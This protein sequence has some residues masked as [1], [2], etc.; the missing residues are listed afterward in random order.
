MQF[1]VHISGKETIMVRMEGKINETADLH[2]VKL[3]PKIP[4]EIDM[5][6]VV[7]MNSIGIRHFRDWTSTM[8]NESVIFSYCPRVFIE[9]VNMIR[10][11]IPP[12]SKILSFYVPYYSEET[13]EEKNVLFVRGEQWKILDDEPEVIEPQVKDSAGNDM[14]VDVLPTKYF[15]FLQRFG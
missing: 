14:S 9:Q 15:Q 2:L 10:D 6:G 4:V 13:G 12:Q 11:L 1:K 3:D 7:S 5:V 8:Q